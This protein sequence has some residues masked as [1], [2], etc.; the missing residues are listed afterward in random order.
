MS[1]LSKRLEP[2]KLRAQRHKKAAVQALKE[3]NAELAKEKF[4]EAH[5]AVEDAFE[6]IQSGGELSAGISGLV[7]QAAKDQAFELADCW[8]IRGGIYRAQGDIEKAIASYE[9]GYAFERNP[10]FAIYSTYNTVNRLVLRLLNDSTLLG[11][12][13]PAVSDG[14]PLAA[15]LQEAAAAIEQKWQQMTDPV[16]ALADMVMIEALL[17]NPDLPEWEKRFQNHAQDRFPFDSLGSVLKALVEKGVP[18]AP[19]LGALA[20]RL[21]D[22]VAQRWP[23]Q[24]QVS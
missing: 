14:K 18:A 11:P 23:E 19:R 10:V 24:V 9:S 7:D 5:Y 21:A 4:D 13:A 2:Y 17:E 8:G 15:L 22:Y 12:G 6:E 16:W 1:A 20:K 3:G